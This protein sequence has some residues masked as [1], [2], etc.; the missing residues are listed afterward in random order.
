MR[1]LLLIAAVLLLSLSGRAQTPDSLQLA[2]L[3][4]KLEEF[5]ASLQS[6]PVAVKNAEADYLIGSCTT[7]AVRD[8]V[9]IRIYDH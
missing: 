8:H 6:E 5:F 2:A 9:A 4:A 1:R 7:D 3:D